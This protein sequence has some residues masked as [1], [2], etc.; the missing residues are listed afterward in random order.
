MR[1]R[2]DTIIPL[3]LAI[4]GGI[5]WLATMYADLNHATA[6]VRSLNISQKD[7]EK[8]LSRI[9]GKLD[10]LIARGNP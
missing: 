8:R 7:I 2:A 3:G 5:L 9:E 4:S 6:E 1:L 10:I